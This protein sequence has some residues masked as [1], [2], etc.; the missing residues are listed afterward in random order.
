MVT[1]N[2]A[3]FTALVTTIRIHPTMILLIRIYYPNERSKSDQ[4]KNRGH[5]SHNEYSF[6]IHQKLKYKNVTTLD[7]NSTPTIRQHTVITDF[8]L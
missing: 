3:N 1:G 6:I 4:Q 8:I 5:H 7:K 2:T